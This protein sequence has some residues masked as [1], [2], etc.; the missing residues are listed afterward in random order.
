MSRDNDCIPIRE[1]PDCECESWYYVPDKEAFGL[2]GCS[3][4]T[5]NRCGRIEDEHGNGLGPWRPN[6][7]Q[8]PEE[9]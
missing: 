8:Q 1:C 3:A 9:S 4:W 6:S 2:Y 7:L 5:C